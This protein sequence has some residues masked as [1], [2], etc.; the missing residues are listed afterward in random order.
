MMKASSI[1]VKI[2]TNIYDA[3]P[4]KETVIYIKKKPFGIFS[5]LDNSTLSSNA[6][7]T[8]F[9]V[10]NNNNPSNPFNNNNR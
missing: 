10:F 1:R 2:L 8:K 7:K 9:V 5:T 4:L 3:I 6:L